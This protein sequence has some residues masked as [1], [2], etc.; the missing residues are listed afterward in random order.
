MTL[1]QDVRT[2]KEWCRTAKRKAENSAA[3]SASTVKAWATGAVPDALKR[4]EGHD[5]SSVTGTCS[6]GKAPEGQ[7]YREHLLHVLDDAMFLRVPA[8]VRGEG[9]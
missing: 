2:V 4:T 6:C 7:G 1:A 9:W 3:D 8:Y 5:F